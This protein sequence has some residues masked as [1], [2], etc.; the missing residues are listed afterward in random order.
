MIEMERSYRE[1][2]S[3]RDSNVC[4]HKGFPPWLTAF[5]SLHPLYKYPPICP[6]RG[7]IYSFACLMVLLCE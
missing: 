7:E 6:C 2:A 1:S 5:P 3:F 4:V